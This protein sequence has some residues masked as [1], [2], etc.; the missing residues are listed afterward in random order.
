LF[1]LLNLFLSS[2]RYANTGVLSLAPLKR[3]AQSERV[4]PSEPRPQPLRAEPLQVQ[5]EEGLVVASVLEELGV[6]PP[7]MIT[8]V[9]EEGRMI[10][11]TAASQAALEPPGRAGSGG[12]DVVMVPSDEDSAPPPP[13]GDVVMS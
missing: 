3:L 4:V 12:V 1:R 6:L 8:A 9:V 2:R 5:V 7:P 10:V 13:A 11:E